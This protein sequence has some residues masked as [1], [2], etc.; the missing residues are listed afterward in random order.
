MPTTQLGMNGKRKM[1]KL[2]FLKAQYEKEYQ[3]IVQN[4]RDSGDSLAVNEQ[5]AARLELEIIDRLLKSIG[6]IKE[7]RPFIFYDTGGGLRS[8]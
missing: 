1:D 6:D 5:E 3:E 8:P 7:E 4:L 2:A